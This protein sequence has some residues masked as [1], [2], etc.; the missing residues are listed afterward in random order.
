LAVDVKTRLILFKLVGS[1]LL[2]S[3]SGAVATGKESVVL[4]AYRG[5]IDL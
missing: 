2:S 5:D 1:G 4:H 3:I